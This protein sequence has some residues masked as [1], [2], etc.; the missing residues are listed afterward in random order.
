V[1][2][3]YAASESGTGPNHGCM[4]RPISTEKA[5]FVCHTTDVPPAIWPAYWRKNTTGD[6]VSLL[7]SLD[8]QNQTD[9]KDSD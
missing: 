2:S 7:P 4:K 6:I 3:G 9:A 5:R 8:S 1:K